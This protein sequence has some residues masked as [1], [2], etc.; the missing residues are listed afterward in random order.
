ML[1]S[2][3]LIVFGTDH[4]SMMSS[5]ECTGKRNP[6]M[7][8]VRYQT[9]SMVMQQLFRTLP[10]DLADYQPRDL[11]SAFLSYHDTA[12]PMKWET[13]FA[14]TPKAFEKVG[15]DLLKIARAGEIQPEMRYHY[16][17]SFIVR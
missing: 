5:P 2:P 11:Q 4:P 16:S 6:D 17:V 7:R 12:P 13:L 8:L 9:D 1:S 10:G 3:T 15:E 14:F